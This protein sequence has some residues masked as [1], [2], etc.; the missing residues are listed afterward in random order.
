[1]KD[2]IKRKTK[3]IWSIWFVEVAVY[4]GC[5]NTLII[6]DDDDDCV[7]VEVFLITSVSLLNANVNNPIDVR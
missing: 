7:L 6:Q 2:L 4:K 1:M 5:G 3:T